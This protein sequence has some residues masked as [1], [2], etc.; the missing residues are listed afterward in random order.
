[1]RDNEFK[2]AL[3]ELLT[4]LNSNVKRLADAQEEVAQNSRPR[5]LRPSR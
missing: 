3:L 1:M 2:A 4:Q 5:P